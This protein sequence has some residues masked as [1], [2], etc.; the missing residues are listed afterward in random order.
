[1]SARL[2]DCWDSFL[3]LPRWVQ[4]WL[5]LALVPVN[6][7]SILLLE[8]PTG[9]AGALAFAV[10]V[11]GNLPIMLVERGMSRLMAVPHLVAWL[12]LLAWLGYSLISSP[13]LQGAERWLAWALLLVNGASLPFDMSDSWRWLRGERAVPR[14]A[15]A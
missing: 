13:G 7:S 6:L 12:P 11:A 5:A 4:L 3:A 2:N 10:V 15:L 14:R 1:V 9:S 8:T